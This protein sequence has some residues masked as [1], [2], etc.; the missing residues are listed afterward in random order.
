MHRFVLLYHDCPPGFIKPSHWDFML[1]ADGV[2]KTWELRELPLSWHE[3]LGQTQSGVNRAVVATQLAD[4]RRDYLTY[5]GPLTE[6]RG[7]VTRIAEGTFLEGEVNDSSL[8]VTLFSPTVRGVVVLIRIA[9]TDEWQLTA[10][11]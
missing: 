4:H 3:T 5:E 6:N 8:T 2:L 1:E 10:G 11:D 9:E 7:N